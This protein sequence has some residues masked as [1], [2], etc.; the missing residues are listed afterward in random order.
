MAPHVFVEDL[1]ISSIA[2]AKV[3]FDT[4]DLRRKLG[5]YHADVGSA[6][7]GWNDIWLQPAFRTWNI[8]DS[9]PD[10]ACPVLLIQGKDDRY[11]SMAQIEAIERQISGPVRTLKLSGCGHSPHVDQPEQT[12]HAIASFVQELCAA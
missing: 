12:L 11:G 2:R 6:F 4:T 1:T 9:L 10:I 8:E 7:H 3:A 5:R